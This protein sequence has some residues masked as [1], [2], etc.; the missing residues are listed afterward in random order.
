M[1]FG[2]FKRGQTGVLSTWAWLATDVRTDENLRK[3]G[4]IGLALEIMLEKRTV[5]KI[6]GIG[7]I[8]AKLGVFDRTLVHIFHSFF[9]CK[10]CIFAYY[11][12]K[13]TL[14]MHIFLFF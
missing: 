11:L 13:F 7:A 12:G 9:P 5:L 4:L 14:F 8:F 6:F 1:G 3:S 10:L 2:A